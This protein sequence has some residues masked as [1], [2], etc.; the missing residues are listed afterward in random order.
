MITFIAFIAFFP[1]F[2]VTFFTMRNQDSTHNVSVFINAELL[3]SQYYN[4]KKHKQKHERN[5]AKNSRK[6]YK[7]KKRITIMKIISSIVLPKMKR[8][9]WDIYKVRECPYYRFVV[10]IIKND[11]REVDVIREVERV[12][13]IAEVEVMQVQIVENED[14]VE[15]QAVVLSVNQLRLKVFL[16]HHLVNVQCYH[17]LNGFLPSFL[18]NHPRVFLMIQLRQLRV[19]NRIMRR[20]RYYLNNAIFLRTLTSLSQEIQKHLHITRRRYIQLQIE[21][22]SWLKSL[23]SK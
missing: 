20:L 2:L 15:A 23:L 16:S 9:C 14:Q 1:V 17:K 3:F 10:V 12:L 8:F 4:R 6:N 5:C 22:K 13:F 18:L 19:L 21:N 11:R 7:K